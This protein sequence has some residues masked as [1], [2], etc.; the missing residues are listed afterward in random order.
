MTTVLFEIDGKPTPIDDCSW[1]MYAPCGCMTGIST[2]RDGV[3]SLDEAWR[4]FEPNAEQR[5]RDEKAGFRV[6]VGLREAAKAISVECPH[7]P[8]WGVAKTPIPKGHQ[9]A[10]LYLTGRKGARKHLVPDIGVENAREHR[11]GAGDTLALCGASGWHW[12]TDWW[13]VESTPE[14]QKCAKQAEA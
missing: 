2:V 7:D 6:E 14:C 13:A 8:K 3:M 1:L 10:R 4:Q 11:Y 5:R 12:K 9:W